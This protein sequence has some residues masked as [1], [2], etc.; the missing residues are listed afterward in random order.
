MGVFF[1]LASS[2]SFFGCGP[3][4]YTPAVGPNQPAEITV[5]AY[6]KQGCLDCLQEEARN[7]NVEVTLKGIQENL[8]GEI[9]VWPFYK[10]FKCTGTVVEPKAIPGDQQ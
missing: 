4:H 6:T 5:S 7:R 1:V 2:L 9:L 8:V 3:K 10:G